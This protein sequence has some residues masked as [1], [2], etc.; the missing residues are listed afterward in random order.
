MP[1]SIDTGHHRQAT[2]RGL[3]CD[4]VAYPDPAAAPSHTDAEASDAP[5]PGRASLDALHQQQ[6]IAETFE[7]RR[8]ESFGAMP[9]PADWNGAQGSWTSA[10]LAAGLVALGVAAGLLGIVGL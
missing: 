1:V 6:A 9:Q 2:D 8:P 7:R 10:G 3:L 4:K 5:T